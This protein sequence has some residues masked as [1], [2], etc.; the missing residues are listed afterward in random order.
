M[1]HS[2]HQQ[3]RSYPSFLSLQLIWLQTMKTSVGICILLL[4]HAASTAPSPPSQEYSN[5]YQ[6]VVTGQENQTETYTMVT[7]YNSTSPTKGLSHGQYIGIIIT[8]VVIAL[9]LSIPCCLAGLSDTW[10][11][12]ADC[13]FAVCQLG[14][15]VATCIEAAS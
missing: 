2:R 8:V 6:V 12:C 13:F 9:I 1:N 7:P 15:A 11:T 4:A 5:Q 3:N 10:R 14:L